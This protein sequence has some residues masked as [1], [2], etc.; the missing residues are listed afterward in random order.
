METHAQ[1]RQAEEKMVFD[2]FHIM[3]HAGDGVEQVRKQEH[4]VLL[5]KGDSTLIRSK[6]L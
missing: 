6:Y 3:K 4:K 1:P 2:R 5:G